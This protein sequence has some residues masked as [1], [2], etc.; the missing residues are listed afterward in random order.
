MAACRATRR[1]WPCSCLRLL[2]CPEAEHLPFESPTST[3]TARVR[4]EGRTAH[5]GVRVFSGPR[6]CRYWGETD[7][8]HRAP[9]NSDWSLREQFEND[10]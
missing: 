8:A 10:R 6:C 5:S 7:R 9:G 3:S 1:G 4:G 2:G